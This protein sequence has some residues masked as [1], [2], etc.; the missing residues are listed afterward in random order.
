MFPFRGTIKRNR[1]LKG[2]LID[3]S[4]A[5]SA[6]AQKGRGLHAEMLKML[7]YGIVCQFLSIFHTKSNTI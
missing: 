6:H 4:H 1:K 3:Y 7:N 2:T 5:T